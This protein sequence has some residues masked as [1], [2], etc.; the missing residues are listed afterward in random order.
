MRVEDIKTNVFEMFNK[1]WCLIAANKGNHFN[2]MTASWGGLGILWNRPVA[3]I[4]IRPQRY[5]KE[6]VDD[7]DY[8][9]ISFFDQTHRDMLNVMGSKS[10][11]DI[12]KENYGGLHGRVQDGFVC[13][14]EALLTVK[15][16]KIYQDSIKP[17]KFL[18]E[19]IGKHYPLED[20]HDMYIGEIVE[21]IEQ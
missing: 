8:F 5:T 15:C 14:D 19:T 3:T 20:Y 16:R 6:F 4:Y 11:R 1:D 13:F 17:E 10:G 12:N 9:T 18:D 21:V 2:M 7:S